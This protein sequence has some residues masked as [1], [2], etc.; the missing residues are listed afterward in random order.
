[1]RARAPRP[2]AAV[3]DP[4]H[5][6][7][8]PRG[9]RPRRRPLDLRG[10]E[11]Q[12]QR[13]AATAASTSRTWSARTASRSSARR[14]SASAATSSAPPRR[15]RATISPSCAPTRPPS[16]HRRYPDAREIFA[17]R[18]WRHVPEHRARVRQR[19]GARG[20][21][22]GSRATTSAP[23]STASPRAR[24]TAARSRRRSARRATTP[25]RPAPTPA[26]AGRARDRAA[27]AALGAVHRLVGGPEQLVRPAAV[28]ASNGAMPDAQRHACALGRRVQRGL[29]VVEQLRRHLLGLCGV[30][31]PQD[32]RR[33]RRRPAARGRRS[34]AAAP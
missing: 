29:D 15:S 13:A 5:F 6:A 34:C 30:D 4:A 24:T 25:S 33:T 28:A 19:E 2:R 14:S 18:G 17:A 21:R 23:R 10:R 22:L 27:A 1:M 20:A 12:G 26:S 16:S 7:L 11:P 9:R 31:A 3:P 32:D 8:L